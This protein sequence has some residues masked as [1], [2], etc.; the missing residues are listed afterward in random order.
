MTR[1][2]FVLLGLANART[3]WFRTVGQWST[4]AML[5]AEFLRCVSV[6]ELRTRLGSGRPFSAAI[7]DGS[8][9]SVDRDLIAHATAVEVAVLVVDGRQRR[10]WRALGAAAVLAQPFSRDELLEVL[11]ATSRPVGGAALGEVVSQPPSLDGHLG[12]V[13]AVT[14]PGGAGASTVAIALAQ[15]LAS[16]ETTAPRAR[17]DDAPSPPSVLLA[18]LCRAADQ[19]MLHDTR[20]VVPGV[21]ELVEAHRTGTPQVTS[22]VE[23]TFDVP[24]RGYRLLL[25]L[26]RSRHWVALR[27]H[28]FEAAMTSL[29]RAADVVVA[30]VED[31]L[32]GVEETGSTDVEERNLMARVAV[33]RAAVVVVVG[34]PSMQGLHALVRSISEVA[35]AGVPA[36]RILP[37]VNLAPKR[38]RARAEL[39]TG[40]ADLLGSSH[41]G[42]T[43]FAPPLFLPERPVDAALRDGVELPAPLP[44]LVARA[45]AAV[46]R[47]AI[48]RDR[49]RMQPPPQRVTP[50]S[51]S[52]FTSE[53]QPPS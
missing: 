10:D 26:R 52:A 8:L 7:V 45:V 19:A 35:G 3:E 15:G 6:E 51:L 37:V 14:G 28:A 32:E 36:D 41:G 49:P 16:G 47:R 29:R 2:R 9:P 39:T 44:R 34:R 11:A 46:R 18:D 48:D 43:A 17:R 20:V 12:D 42:S 30:D 1:E 53:E 23:Q 33:A 27:P 38:P 4:S 40:L 24:A 22:L 31:D 50:G 13:V 21:Q 5:P 25:G